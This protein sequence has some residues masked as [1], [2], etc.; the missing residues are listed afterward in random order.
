MDSLSVLVK[1]LII[2]I[3]IYVVSYS[4]YLGT[5]LFDSNIG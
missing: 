5:T 4:S 1:G 3:K 2:Q